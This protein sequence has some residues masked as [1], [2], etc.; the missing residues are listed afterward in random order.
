MEPSDFKLYDIIPGVSRIPFSEWLTA[1]M[2]EKGWSNADLAN[3]AGINRQVIWGWLNRN[4]KPSQEM[5]KAIAKALE[6]PV[7]Q[8]YRAAG[9]L[10]PISDDDEWIEMI[11]A[12]A[13]QLPNDLKESVWRT[14]KSLREMIE[15]RGK[16]KN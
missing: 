4:K 15:S 16:K 10:P 9:G 8:V 7:E 14:A 2:Q 12:E 11:E 5:L 3:A 1:R 6:L 13:R